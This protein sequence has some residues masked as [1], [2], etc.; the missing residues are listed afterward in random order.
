MDRITLH[1]FSLTPQHVR[2]YSV[3]K[4]SI[5]ICAI[6]STGRQTLTELL[7]VS[8]LFSI[9][10]LKLKFRLFL[11]ELNIQHLTSLNYIS[12]HFTISTNS[13]SCH[14]RNSQTLSDTLRSTHK[15]TLS[16]LVTLRSREPWNLISLRWCL[17]AASHFIR[18]LNCVGGCCCWSACQHTRHKL[19][20]WVCFISHRE[21]QRSFMWSRKYM[22]TSAAST[23]IL[24]DEDIK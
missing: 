8:W 2:L 10:H 7:S 21:G 5:F 12:V 16:V 4:S 23:H 14:S 15:H 13:K 19:D 6:I 9:S 11:S 1:C 18:V 17:G 22:E 20:V 3:I 24:L